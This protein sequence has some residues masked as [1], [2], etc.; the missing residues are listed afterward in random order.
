MSMGNEGIDGIIPVSPVDIAAIATNTMLG[1]NTGGSAAPTALTV[2]ETQILLT[3]YA[4]VSGSNVTRTAQTLAD[5]TGLT[6]ALSASATYIFEAV[7]SVGTSADTTGA[8]Y[9]VQF[10]A[11]GS[12]VEAQIIG[13]ST[14][15]ATKSERITALNTATSAY[16]TTS[17]QSGQVLIKG[18]LVTTTNAGNLTIQHLKVVSGTSTVFIK[19]YLKATRVV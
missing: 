16:L 7:L 6:L 9:A 11:G 13:S 15:T 17:T 1:N 10:S 2:E 14:S 8:E 19:S 12:T 3:K 18:V 4:A 5:I